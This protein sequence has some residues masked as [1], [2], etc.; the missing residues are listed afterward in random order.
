[1]SGDFIFHSRPFCM[2][3]GSTALVAVPIRSGSG[4]SHF[5]SKNCS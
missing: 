4:S 1:M 2:T 3:T 5:S